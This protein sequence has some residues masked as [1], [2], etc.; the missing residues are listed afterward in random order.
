MIASMSPAHSRSA[1]NPFRYAHPVGIDDLIDRDSETEL[2]LATAVETNN[3]RLVAPRRFGK[4]SLLRRVL[5]E[6]GGDG[7]TGVY[8]DFFGVLTLGDVA[9]RVER[10]YALSLTGRAARWFD[11]VR[12]A[13]APTVSA[14]VGPVRAGAQV[15]P[16]TPSLAER[17]DLPL[18]LFDRFGTRTLV[19]FDEFQEVLVA[20]QAA[21]SVIRA[22]I[23]HHDEA[24]SYI[25][26]GS[27]VGMMT[28]L[29]GD[30]R[31]AFY[32]QARPVALPPLT[33]EDCAAFIADRFAE[34]GKDPGSALR[35]LLSLAAGHPQ[36]TILLAHAVWEA[37]PP[38]ATADEETFADARAA[39]G[40]ELDDEFRTFWSA[41]PAGQR[42]A[43]VS[44]ARG[45]RPYGT[46]SVG[47]SRG[48]AVRSALQ[49]LIE[50]GD[51][52]VDADG[53]HHL[54]DPLLADWIARRS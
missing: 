8:V 18:R 32:A 53:Q 40:D 46:T 51:L 6:A 5:G 37:T 26:A 14:G 13:F 44:V 25:F 34:T 49:S 54:V 9:D 33:A 23:Q 16:P 42:R 29:F 3:S 39:V 21:D 35:P 7:W 24:A 4:T 15:R 27:H 48:G 1:V 17:L 28:S 31:R 20:D 10:A 30:R 12:A 36:R 38:G 47:G 19:V 2:L 22:S 41:L 50:R 11:G 52:V 45:E 43:L